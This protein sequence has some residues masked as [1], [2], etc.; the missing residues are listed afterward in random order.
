MLLT[1]VGLL[2][3]SAGVSFAVAK[4]VV[5]ARPPSSAVAVP[6]T[7]EVRISARCLPTP[8]VPSGMDCACDPDEVALSGGG[9]CGPNNPIIESAAIYLGSSENRSFGAWRVWCNGAPPGNA[10]VLCT[11]GLRAPTPAPP[12]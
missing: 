1:S 11:K 8:G 3:A 5:A 12:P 10:Y 9:W 4:S 2:A 7:Q 6:P